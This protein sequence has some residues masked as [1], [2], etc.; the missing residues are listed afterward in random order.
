MKTTVF[1]LIL[2]SVLTFAGLGLGGMFT[3][4]EVSSFWYQQLSKAPWTPPGWVFG[5]AWSTIM[6]CLS[7]Y[8]ATAWKA[9]KKHKTLI[10]AF[11]L[12]WILNVG[13]SPVFFYFHEVALGFIIITLLTMLIA[14]M[15]VHF[16]P[17]MRTKTLLLLPYLIWLMI[18][19]SLNGF[20][21]MNN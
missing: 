6:I 17:D 10:I 19:T 14:W 20:I 4:S 2:F 1:R 21:V 8:M 5:F 7:I 18:A 3:G 9:V 16:N 15:I 12:Q 13:W 11:I